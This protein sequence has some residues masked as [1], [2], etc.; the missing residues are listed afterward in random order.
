MPSPPTLTIELDRA[1]PIPLYFQV[2]RQ[3]EQAIER[4]DLVPGSRLEN[5]I[6]LADRLGLSRPTMRQAIQELVSKGLLV[7]RRGIGTQVVHGQVKRR[8]EL[9]SLHDDLT[10]GNQHPTT[11][12]LAHEALIAPDEIAVPL[13]LEPG[14]TVVR[15]ERLRFAQDEP[16]AIL[17][18]WL[19]ADIATFGTE[20]LEERGLYGLLRSSGVHIRIATQR[21]GARTATPEEAKL[22]RIKRGAAVLTMERTAYGESGHAVE[23]GSHIYRSDNYSFEVTLV[24]RS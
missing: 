9:T 8:V 6:E 11:Q 2:A 12:V 19:P 23:F 7:R 18:N 3:I 10:R 5:E 15:L 16:L 20:E 1:S 24:E 21:I 22:L 14:S 13:G 17:R 4:G